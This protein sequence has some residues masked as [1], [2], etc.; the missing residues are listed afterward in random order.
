MSYSSRCYAV[1]H[2]NFCNLCGIKIPTKILFYILDIL[3][4]KSPFSILE[5]KVIKY[6]KS[7]YNIIFEIARA[8]V[9]N[10]HF[11]VTGIELVAEMC[12]AK[13]KGANIG[14]TEIEFI[15]GKIQGGHYTADTRTAG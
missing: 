11:V 10:V 6:L 4:L 1:L 2:N 14:S 13:L 5:Q 15:P 7:I 8:Y 12:Q 3:N 9:I